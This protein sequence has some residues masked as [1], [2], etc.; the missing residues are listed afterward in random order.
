MISAN[1]ATAM[2]TTPLNPPMSLQPASHLCHLFINLRIPRLSHRVVFEPHAGFVWRLSC[3]PFPPWR[4]YAKKHGSPG[5]I[6]PSARVSVLLPMPLAPILVSRYQT[7]P[8]T[9]WCGKVNLYQH[10]Y[11]LQLVLLSQPIM[12]RRH[13]VLAASLERKSPTRRHQSILSHHRRLTR[14]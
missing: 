5:T 11:R 8:N 10:L 2:P 14:S 3:T 13:V 7:Y 4:Q 9:L 12:P 6:N 1:L